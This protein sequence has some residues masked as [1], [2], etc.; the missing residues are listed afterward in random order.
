MPGWAVPPD[1]FI[2]GVLLFDVSMG[3]LVNNLVVKLMNGA[4]DGSEQS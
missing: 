2:V 3:T 4:I 1:C